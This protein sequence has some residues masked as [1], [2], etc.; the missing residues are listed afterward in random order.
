MNYKHLAAKKLRDAIMEALD[1]V[2]L[3]DKTEQMPS[4]LSGGQA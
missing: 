1:A 3:P 2:G 4:D